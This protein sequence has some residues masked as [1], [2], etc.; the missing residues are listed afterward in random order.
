MHSYVKMPKMKKSEGKTERKEMERGGEYCFL[1][2]TSTKD[3]RRNGPH[4]HVER[5]F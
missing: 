3:R 4:I 1:E 2:G 5:D